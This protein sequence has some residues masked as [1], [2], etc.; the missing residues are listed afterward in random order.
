MLSELFVNYNISIFINKSNIPIYK[1]K[2]EI[3]S[4][5][6][7]GYILSPIAMYL[8]GIFYVFLFRLDTLNPKKA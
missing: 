1:K 8:T 4:I 7:E 6:S 5:L 2:E 3:S